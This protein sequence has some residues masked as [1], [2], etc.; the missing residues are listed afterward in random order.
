MNDNLTFEDLIAN[1]NNEGRRTSR[2]GGLGGRL[3]I[4]QETISELNSR[5]TMTSKGGKRTILNEEMEDIEESKSD[6]LE[7]N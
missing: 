5:R 3:A 6:W 7:D 2:M 4:N 1:S